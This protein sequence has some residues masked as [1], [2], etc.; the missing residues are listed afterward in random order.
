[1]A[2]VVHREVFLMHNDPDP[3]VCF[4]CGEPVSHEQ[5]HVHHI[6]EDRSNQDPANLVAV[7]IGCHTRLHF[8]GKSRSPEVRAKIAA[9]HLGKVG[10]PQ[11]PET[12]AR[13]STA[14]KGR[15]ISDETKA[16]LRAAWVARRAA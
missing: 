9:A 14:L 3:W 2:D 8:T 1:M 5:L 4:G 16:R 7:H 10:H 13:I 15:V 6:D 11:S 12:R